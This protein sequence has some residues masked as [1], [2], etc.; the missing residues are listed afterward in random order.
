MQVKLDTM[1]RKQC[2]GFIATFTAAVVILFLAS[3]KAEDMLIYNAGDS[4]A[5]V[6]SFEEAK[7]E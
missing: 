1:T 7:T 6:H 4:Y 5:C 2:I 3:L